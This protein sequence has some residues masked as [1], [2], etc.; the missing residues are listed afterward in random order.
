MKKLSKSLPLKTFFL[1]ILAVVFQSCD[2]FAEDPL[3]VSKYDFIYEREARDARMEFHNRVSMM[4]NNEMDPVINKAIMVW[5][6]D[7]N[8]EKFNRATEAAL[9]NYRAECDRL[10]KRFEKR[11]RWAEKNLHANSKEEAMMA[12]TKISNRS[13]Q[14]FLK[15]F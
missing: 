12:V 5:R 8:K 4:A 10:Q 14:N 2:V 1:L 11:M 13:L 9:Q 15:N 3:Q 6:G 7:G